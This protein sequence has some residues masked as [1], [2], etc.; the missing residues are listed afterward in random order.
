MQASARGGFGPRDR[1]SR[2]MT[3]LNESPDASV[4]CGEFLPVSARRQRGRNRAPREIASVAGGGAG[5]RTLRVQFI[6]KKRVSATCNPK[7]CRP[8]RPAAKLLGGPE[9]EVFLKTHF[10]RQAKTGHY[11]GEHR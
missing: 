1:R 5:P 3:A 8:C 11:S 10:A 2:F 6:A 4:D 7:G 9:N